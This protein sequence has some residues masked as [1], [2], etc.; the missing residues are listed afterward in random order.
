[1]A[2]MFITEKLLQNGFRMEGLKGTNLRRPRMTFA[3]GCGFEDLRASFSFPN[4][5]FQPF[6]IPSARASQK[7]PVKLVERGCLRRNSQ[8]EPHACSSTITF[9]LAI[10]QEQT[11]QQ[12]A[13]NLQCPSI[14]NQQLVSSSSAHHRSP[15]QRTGF[16]IRKL[17][18]RCLL[19][20]T[21]SMQDTSAETAKCCCRG[22][23]AVHLPQIWL[24]F[25][26]AFGTTTPQPK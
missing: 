3:A 4:I 23:I 7:G 16:S 13:S 1:M 26:R 25:G 14:M 19:S 20:R 17:D 11:Y 2:D 8:Q 18:L 10:W 21:E 9:T 6:S 24:S 22:V 5:L 12:S 15:V